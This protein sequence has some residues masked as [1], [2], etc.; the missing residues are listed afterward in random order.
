[1]AALFANG[2]SLQMSA[3]MMR[4]TKPP[5]CS[6]EYRVHLR[7]ASQFAELLM[8]AADKRPPQKNAP[9]AERFGYLV[10]N[11]YLDHPHQRCAQTVDQRTVHW[12][13]SGGDGRGTS[14]QG[15]SAR[16]HQR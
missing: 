13:T 16:A 6:G 11:E 8:R 14:S 2:M 12:K 4:N 7:N 10:V 3:P 5:S 9:L 15:A 1:M